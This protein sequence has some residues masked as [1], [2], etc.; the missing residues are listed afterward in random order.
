MPEQTPDTKNSKPPLPHIRQ[1]LKKKK[2]LGL[3]HPGPKTQGYLFC[4]TIQSHFG[5][6]RPRLTAVLNPRKAVL[7]RDGTTPRPCTHGKK[8]KIGCSHVLY[9]QGA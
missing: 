3:Q 1:H 4:P 7:R 8:E 9:K 5:L 2:I 6:Y